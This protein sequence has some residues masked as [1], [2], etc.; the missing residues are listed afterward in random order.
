MNDLYQRTKILIGEENLN[1][2]KESKVCIF[3]VGGVGSYV[4]EALARIGVGN[5]TIVDK[6]VVDVTNINRQLIALSTN[7]GNSK[8]E[9][10]KK[11]IYDI[12]PDIQVNAINSFVDDNNVEQYITKDLDYVIDAIDTIESK[13]AIIRRCK[14]LGVSIISSMG[15]AN[16]L[17]P[18]KI[19]IADISKTEVCPL[20]KI[21][22]KRL[23]EEKISKVKVIFSVENPIKTGEKTLGSVSFVPSA[24]GLIIASEVVK[25]LMKKKD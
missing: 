12:N 5:I 17:D 11:R 7:I 16:R 20:A 8:V 13:I 2:L 9:E 21:V 6:D 3:G 10:F 24:G 22:R 23:R 18:L 25:D 1:L 14:K 15:M 4:V 19:K